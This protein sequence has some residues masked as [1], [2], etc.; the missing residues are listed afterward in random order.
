MIEFDIF[1]KISFVVLFTNIINLPRLIIDLLGK[2]E[3][4]KM[5]LRENRRIDTDS[6][7]PYLLPK[8]VKN[9][10]DFNFKKRLK[11]QLFCVILSFAFV[12][13]YL[14]TKDIPY[15]SSS[16][17]YICFVSFCSFLG[18]LPVFLSFVIMIQI[19]FRIIGLFSR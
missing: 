2:I 7:V 4:K 16:S 9:I 6:G 18:L 11:T 13:I 12:I 3:L 17:Y 5:E 8:N 14:F 10:L 19:S 15:I 1:L